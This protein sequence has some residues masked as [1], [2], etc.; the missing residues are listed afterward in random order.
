[1]GM[2]LNNLD[3]G[4]L[5]NLCDDVVANIIDYLSLEEQMAIRVSF[6]KLNAI[7]IPFSFKE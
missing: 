5:A 7:F 6:K 1:V 3:N 4:A 2:F